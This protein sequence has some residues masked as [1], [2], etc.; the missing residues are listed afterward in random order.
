MFRLVMAQVFKRR[1]EYLVTYFPRCEEQH[2]PLLCM[3]CSSMIIG[4]SYHDKKETLPITKDELWS[5]NSDLIQLMDNPRSYPEQHQLDF[6]EALLLNTYASSV[7]PGASPAGGWLA[8]GRLHHAALLVGL[9]KHHDETLQLSHVLNISPILCVHPVPR[10]AFVTEEALA[11]MYDAELAGTPLSEFPEESGT[12]EWAYV[13]YT[14]DWWAAQ[15]QVGHIMD[16]TT[17]A[18]SLRERLRRSLRVRR[19]Q[20][21]LASPPAAT[22]TVATGAALV[23]DLYRPYFLEEAVA[24]RRALHAAESL[25]NTAQALTAFLM[26][27]WIDAQSAQ[28]WEF[29]GKVFNGGLT[30]AYALL[31]G[32][33]EW[34]SDSGFETS[35]ASESGAGTWRS[36]QQ[37]ALE[38]AIGA[39]RACANQKTHCSE[40]SRKSLKVLEILRTV[41]LQRQAG[42]EPTHDPYSQIISVL[43]QDN[44]EELEDWVKWDGIFQELFTGYN[45][46]LQGIA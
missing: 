27:R 24:L 39:L 22:R 11:K 15:L 12:C 13:H 40:L 8:I 3:L 34:G 45:D 14:A 5:I 7:G 17:P 29:G 26:F 44:T 33:P 25:I 35:P 1:M 6:C 36:Q 16:P 4:Y 46:I 31:Q 23:I 9:P 42:K 30:M 19:V 43:N 37:T 32:T 2:V 28:L 20:R 41:I 21:Y 38:T 18:A 10:P